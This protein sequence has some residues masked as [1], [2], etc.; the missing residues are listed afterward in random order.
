[1]P[2]RKLEE[3][4][5]AVWADHISGM[6]QQAIADKY[7]ISQQRVSQIIRAV[8]ES[9][10]DPDKPKFV[11]REIDFLD[12]IRLRMIE[13]IDA[14][15]P[16]AFQKGE[17]LQYV[18]PDTGTIVTVRDQSVRMAAV[19]RALKSHQLL[20]PLLGLAAP[21]DHNVN[22]TGD[23]AEAAK[24]AAADAAQYLHGDAT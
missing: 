16:P 10:E 21:S 22:I 5:G 14:E 11:R 15:L 17:I 3:R 6:S 13:E 2:S 19:D 12:A 1:M 4:N 8:E 18:D 23:A 9:I 7:S 20:S 24:K